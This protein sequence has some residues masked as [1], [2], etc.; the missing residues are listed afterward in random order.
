MSAPNVEV[1]VEPEPSTP[2][3]PVVVQVPSEETV[4]LAGEAGEL[5]ARVET[6]TQEL[7]AAK[8]ELE[9]L[10]SRQAETERAAAAAATIAV[11]AAETATEAVAEE[12]PEPELE[13]TEIPV[14]PV[15]EEA[16]Q[17]GAETKSPAKG[18]HPI[19]ALFLGKLP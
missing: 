13:V 1:K 9:T 16:G 3:A 7:S 12:E 8:S 14:P 4:R 15:V 10:K 17:P 18:R 6:M 2:A 11:A 19:A 5:R